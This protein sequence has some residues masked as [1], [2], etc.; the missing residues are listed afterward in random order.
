MY[1]APSS[2]HPARTKAGPLRQGVRKPWSLGARLNP[3]G[4]AR[5]TSKNRRADETYDLPFCYRKG[6]SINHRRISKSLCQSVHFEHGGS[7][8][9]PDQLCLENHPNCRVIPW[10]F[11]NSSGRSEK[12]VAD[13]PD[14][15]VLGT[16]PVMTLLEFLQ[17][18][19][20]K[21]GHGDLLFWDP[22]VSTL[23]LSLSA[24]VRTAAGRSMLDGNWT[25]LRGMS[26][27]ARGIRST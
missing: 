12:T 22:T 15:R 26:W 11:S 20:A 24:E 23:S 9:Q 21:L 3:T 8:R 6:D 14:V 16:I 1:I 18:L 19:L 13:D 2:F 7:P 10:L 27:R 5:D 25:R 17:H 4:M